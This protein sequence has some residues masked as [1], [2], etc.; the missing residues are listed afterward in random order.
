MATLSVQIWLLC[1]GIH[2]LVAVAAGAYGRHAA[3]DAGARELFA[4]GAQYQL[5]H[6]LALVGVAWLAAGEAEG[7]LSPVHFAG[8]A[9]A[10]GALLFAGALYGFGLT[11]AVPIEGAAPLGGWL[12]MLGWLCL[13]LTAVRNLVR[14]RRGR[15]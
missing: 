1:A 12:L 6:A 5:A 4:I 3:L 9:F 11:G 7:K 14:L 13:A 2:G 10:V 8:A 15:R